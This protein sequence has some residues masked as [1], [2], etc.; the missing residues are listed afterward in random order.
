V[1]ARIDAEVRWLIDNAHTVALEILTTYRSVLD[2]LA[3]AL[4]EKETLETDEVMAILNPVPKWIVPGSNGAAR[5]AVPRASAPP[6]SS[7]SAAASPPP[8]AV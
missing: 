3:N 4:M 8:E 2:N 6:A 1:A 5:A 7:P